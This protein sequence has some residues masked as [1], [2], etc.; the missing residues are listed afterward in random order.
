MKTLTSKLFKLDYADAVATFERDYIQHHLKLSGYDIKKASEHRKIPAAK[1]K[2]ELT[3]FV[4]RVN[5]Q[6]TFW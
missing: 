1:L 2:K 4:K 5:N 6:C 3:V